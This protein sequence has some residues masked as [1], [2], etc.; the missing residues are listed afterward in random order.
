MT[1]PL[2]VLIADDEAP[3]RERLADILAQHH[4]TVL[5]ASCST[6]PETISAIAEHHP[7]IAFLD[8]QMPGLSGLEVVRQL[9]DNRRPLVVFVTAFDRYAL[10]AFEAHAIDYLLKPFSD[11]RFAD[12][13][14]RA[15]E[16]VRGNTMIAFEERLRAMLRSWPPAAPAPAER[17]R[18]EDRITVRHQGRIQIIRAGTVEW[19][20]V[21]GEFLVLH[22][23]TDVL[24]MRGTLASLKRRLSADAFVQVHRSA[25]VNLS[26][27]S[28]AFP[29]ASG[30]LTLVMHSGAHI[31]VSRRYRAELKPYLD[32]PA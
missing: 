31:V 30:H 6:G 4:T 8:V 17:T 12:A 18:P 5:V 3:A 21:D 19:F 1:A 16:L 13:L 24:R 25:I 14:H 10:D 20:E 11:E 22:R 27:I 9:P 29:D 7:D 2:R 23:A 15:S 26:Q 28:L 32:R